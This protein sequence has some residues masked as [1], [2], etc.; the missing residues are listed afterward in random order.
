[1]TTVL[2]LQLI[3]PVFSIEH[4]DPMFAKDSAQDWNKAIYRSLFASR[5]LAKLNLSKQCDTTFELKKS[6]A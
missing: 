6:M 1:M 3:D 2:M 4:A 5:S